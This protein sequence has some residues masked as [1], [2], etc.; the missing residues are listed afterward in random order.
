MDLF[1]FAKRAKP[2][3]DKQ[4]PGYKE[5]TTSKDAAD[6]MRAASA[7]LRVT[8]LKHLLRRPSTVHE[9]AASLELTVVAVAPRFTELRRLG[10]IEPSGER[11]KNDSGKSAH[12][13]RATAA[14]LLT[15]NQEN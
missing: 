14:G 12:V 11:R 5:P 7:K 9:A 2:Y 15:F 10:L 8:V 3:G 13:W 1:E 4:T 6:A